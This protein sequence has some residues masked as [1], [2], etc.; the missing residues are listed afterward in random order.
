MR[1]DERI[2]NNTAPPQNS[3]RFR[4]LLRYIFPI[5][6]IFLAF[7]VASQ[8][9]LTLAKRES[10]EN[11]V[12]TASYF[13]RNLDDALTGIQLSGYELLNSPQAEMVQRIAPENALDTPSVRAGT[14]L[15]NSLYT[16]C[17][18]YDLSEDA[19]LYY[20]A[21]D[22]VVSRKGYLTAFQYLHLE[23][24]SLHPNSS[25]AKELHDFFFSP[26]AEGFF[27]ERDPVDGILQMFYVRRLAK[28]G[29]TG[30]R[31]LIMRFDVK[32]IR[33]M[34]TRLI[35]GSDLQYIAMLSD[36]GEILTSA[37]SIDGESFAALEELQENMGRKVFYQMHSF[38]W[39][40][41]FC[42]V[43]SESDA[44]SFAYTLF[45]LSLFAAIISTVLGL[46][47]AL[48]VWHEN[49]QREKKLLDG[50]PQEIRFSDDVYSA[51]NE[52]LSR[53]YDENIGLIEQMEQ[54]SCMMEST[55]LKE[56]LRQQNPSQ[57]DIDHLCSAYDIALENDCFS[58]IAAVS[59]GPSV[60][61]K[62]YLFAFL[63]EINR[64]D[65]QVFWTRYERV[66]VF[67]CNYE[68]TS[69]MTLREFGSLI[70]ERLPEC[71]VI[72][73]PQILYFATDIPEYFRD[74]YTR[75]EM[76]LEQVS[77]NA[78]D[79]P[80]RQGAVEQ[81]YDIILREYGNTQLSL[82]M[83]AERLGVSSAYLS[84]A[85]K[86]KYHE[87]LLHFLNRIRV[88][89]A[90]ELL[91]VSDE[92]LNVIAQQVGF[93]SDMNLIRVFKK[94]ESETPGSFRKRQGD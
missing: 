42:F 69:E 82:S 81:A 79:Y 88:D 58:L 49:V 20:P 80:V 9:T 26:E 48:R 91:L 94:L 62:D 59:R 61:K 52:R 8:I 45:R 12:K 41:D 43:Q 22:R 5:T 63:R 83:L 72:R 89:H 3:R 24:H 77:G 39:K 47:L 17:M 40:E 68:R 65:F 15:S 13:V 1:E 71:R 10:R 84:R 18:T 76:L 23:F 28:I 46:L 30:E 11:N 93:L 31:M 6:V 38:S 54:K 50:L 7:V 44:Y 16:F 70:E 25:E 66:D 55:F 86:Q 87:N 35:E 74:Q 27:A 85:F 64:D 14:E 19:V 29:S 53:M 67:L 51:I 4:Q 56:L 90:K 34:M 36:T 21:L 60:V 92:S 32:A 33:E 78:A 57:H 2:E 75:I 73:M 37:G